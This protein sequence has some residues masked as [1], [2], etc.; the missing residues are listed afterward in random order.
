MKS[1]SQY[2]FARVPTVNA[3]RS[4]FDRSRTYKT[5]MDSGK[6]I[7]IFL[8]D[9]LPGDTFNLSLTAFMR[10]TTPI[11][12]FMDNLKAT[13]FFFYVPS[14]LVWQ[15][16]KR[17]MG[18]QDNPT[19]SIS[20]TVPQITPPSGQGFAIGSLADY[21]GLP[22]GIANLSVD[23]MP[24]RCYN[25]VWNTWFRD[26]NLQNSLVVDMDETTVDDTNYQ[27]VR[28]AKK[29]D[30]FT[31]ALPWPQKGPG[32]ELPL[33]TQAPVFGDGYG[34]LMSDGTSTSRL[35]SGNDSIIGSI[36][37]LTNSTLGSIGDSASVISGSDKLVGVPTKSSIQ[38]GGFKSSGLYAD[39]SSA[40]AATINSLRTAFQI[41]HL[42]EA[43]ARGG[44]RYNELVLSCFQ[45][46]VPDARLQRPEY[47]GGGV[48]PVQ[49]HSV[50]QTSNSSAGNTPQGNLA[51]YGLAGGRVGFSKSFV[52]HGYV[53]GLVCIDSDITYQQGIDRMWSRKTRFDF[54]WPQ[55]AHL[56]EQ[57]I[58]NKEI[59]AQGDNVV[60]GQGRIVDNLPFGYQ[61]RW[62]EYRYG[63]S[64]ITGELRSTYAQSLDVW[65][66]SEEFANLPTL[67][68]TFIESNPPVSRVLA[69]QNRPQFIYDSLVTCRCV[70]PMPTFSVPGWADHF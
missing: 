61:E 42:Y 15:N 12:P 1:A 21:F 3:P 46:Q 50:T 20:Y 26:E 43:L 47:L 34:L 70:R 63:V 40:T 17:F 5:T 67:S 48:V 53:L 4:V 13:F 54:Y 57:E 37:Q 45:V 23:A 16:F 22:T 55:L 19:D 62:S 39:L 18:E 30:Y 60:D 59:Y 41:Q 7:P 38:N 25:L 64:H 68:S 58:L 11:V 32:V 10:L 9:V 52:E 51:A 56:G 36:V 29:H 44:S 65:H 66:L 2:S 31:S 6:L 27:V 28:R 69:V 14:R 33:G 49:I 8:D 24:F 35:R